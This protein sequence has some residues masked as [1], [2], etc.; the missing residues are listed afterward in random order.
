MKI[1]F[2]LFFLFTA[3]ILIAQ[4]IKNYTWDIAPKFN[5]IPEIYKNEPA[6]VFFDKRE[7]FTRV[8]GYSFATFVMN[9][10]AVKINKAESINDYNKIKAKDVGAIRDLRD[11]HARIIKPSGEIKVLSKDKI[12]EREVDKVKS[13]VFEGVEVGDIL[14]YYFILKENPTSYAVEIFQKEIP[15]LY[16][17]FK[18]Q[19]SGVKF[20][21][22]GVE[23]FKLNEVNQSTKIYTIENIEPF[24][25]EKSAANIKHLKK[26]IYAVSDAGLPNIRLW[27]R[28]MPSYKKPSFVY[29]KKKI[30]E[31]FI[32]FLD[33][34]NTNLNT[35]D[36]IIKLE[37]YLKEN[38][39]LIQTGESPEK[40]KALF[41][42]KLKLSA[43]DYFDLYGFI[44]KELGIDYTFIV[45]TDRF[46]SEINPLVRVPAYSYEI[47]YYINETKKYISPYE[48]Y[49]SYGFPIY[50]F[51]GSN[52]IAYNP[53][54]RLPEIENT[55]FP[56]IDSKLTQTNSESIISLNKDLSKINFSKKVAYTGYLGQLFR[57]LIAE[58]KEKNDEK[59][60]KKFVEDRIFSGIGIKMKDFDFENQGIKNNYTN[61]PLLIKANIEP[62]ETFIEEAGNLLIVNIGKAIAK[63]G[64]LYQEKN[65]KLDIDLNFAQ[66][67]H[68]TIKIEI[69]E[70]FKVE[71]I[72]DFS[73]SIK[74]TGGEFEN[75]CYFDSSA[76]IEGNILIVQANEVYELI[77]YPV[78]KFEEYRN[79]LNSAADFFKASVILKPIK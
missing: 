32:Q 40:I 50:E 45:G 2:I 16:G 21:L 74:M 42:D 56:I 13:I 8:G 15:V 17:E 72:K 14:E 51:Q 54:K 38:I 67:Y 46:V 33:L 76:K 27:K 35:D 22:Y 44:L 28:I 31:D 37:N 34:K 70:G 7:V 43:S 68:H 78:E 12:V 4:D 5:S 60:M 25:N 73:K 9:H 29:F 36:K 77:H 57:N 66:Q 58:Y 75:K 30:V 1:R 55:I 20:D 24:K 26:L 65:R 71:N 19:G 39:Q 61:T 47:M 18:C 41:P 3:S 23:D 10:F 63:Q 53:Q 49:L 59:E 69:P 79:V 11:F 48:K 52:G 62:T 64:D 6:I